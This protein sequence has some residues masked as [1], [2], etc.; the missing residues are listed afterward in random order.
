MCV[1]IA[2]WPVQN[3]WLLLNRENGTFCNHHVGARKIQTCTYLENGYA[4]EDGTFT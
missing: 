4:Y 3:F 1:I 2:Q